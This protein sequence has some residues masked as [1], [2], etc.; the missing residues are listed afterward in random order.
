MNIPFRKI[1]EMNV[2]GDIILTNSLDGIPPAQETL[3]SATRILEQN[4]SKE[5]ENKQK[6]EYR[7][8]RRVVDAIR[9]STNQGLMFA[10]LNCNVSNEMK[11]KLTKLNYNVTNTCI[12]GYS[13]FGNTIATVNDYTKI[14]WDET[15]LE[16]PKE[17]A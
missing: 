2:F 11:T 12:T 6:N 1:F 15:S 8:D 5:A 3:N 14:S 13:N 4:R 7:C 16:S 9:K 10:T 17:L